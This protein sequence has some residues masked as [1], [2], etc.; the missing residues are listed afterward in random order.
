MTMVLSGASIRRVL[1][2]VSIVSAIGLSGAP[3]PAWSWS[4]GDI[5]PIAQITLDAEVAPRATPGVTAG[6]AFKNGKHWSGAAGSANKD[7][8]KKLAAIDQMRIGSQ[9]K[10]YT[11]TIILQ[12]VQEGKISLDD[13]LEKWLPALNVPQ[14]DKITIRNLLDM[15]SGVPEY[16]GAPAAAL[17]TPVPCPTSQQT[18]L[19]EW[20]VQRGLMT[21]KPSDL[22]RASNCLANTG[23]GRCPTATPTSCCS[24]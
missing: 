4:E 12:M 10:T 14:A 15:T 3:R 13:T 17:S 20:V 19:D 9:T 8:T 24:G 7:G 5:A 16:L 18:V 2:G 23:V 11:G 6:I 22:V 21:A 1:A